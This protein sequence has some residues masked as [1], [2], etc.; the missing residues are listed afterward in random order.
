MK[1][2]VIISPAKNVT[3]YITGNYSKGREVVWTS[4][5][6]SE[7]YEDSEFQIDTIESMEKDLFYLLDYISLIQGDYLEVLSELCIKKIEESE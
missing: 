2:S 7:P 5:G 1:Q 3:L 4:F 6:E